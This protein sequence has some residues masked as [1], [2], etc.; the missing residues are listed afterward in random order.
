MIYYVYYIIMVQSIF[1]I[2]HIKRVSEL[3]HTFL[4]DINNMMVDYH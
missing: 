4:F 2:E 1:F 3:P